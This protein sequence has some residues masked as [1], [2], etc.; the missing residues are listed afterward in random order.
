MDSNESAFIKNTLGTGLLGGIVVIIAI[1]LANF[2]DSMQ[3]IGDYLAP[4]SIIA[5]FIGISLIFFEKSWIERII[6]LTITV[7]F[8]FVIIRIFNI[9]I[10]P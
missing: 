5:G 2:F 8:A 6:G 1:L 3:G 7:I 4:I 9:P 10:T